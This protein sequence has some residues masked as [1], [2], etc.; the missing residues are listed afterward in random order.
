MSPLA[1]FVADETLPEATFVVPEITL[2]LAREPR[3]IYQRAFELEGYGKPPLWAYAWPGGQALARYLLDW[4]DVARGK[5]V[6]D[7]GS[8]SGIQA[9]AALKSG[10]LSVLASDIDPMAEIVI[11]MNAAANGVSITATTR[12]IL[13]ERPDAD[14]V[15]I[16]DLVY[17][18]ELETRV[19]AF[20]DMARTCGVT[21]LMGDR[22][23]AR[24]PPLAFE[25]LAEY[26]APCTPPLLEGFVERAR[27]WRL[28]P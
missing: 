16:G 20:L 17:E 2:R 1:R 13:G 23:T 27:V 25:L 10:A 11:G 7:L 4:P 15:L 22:T 9:I 3:E 21:V 26:V 28:E 24:R 5:R 14:L 6:L 19:G 12:D 18:P 8:G